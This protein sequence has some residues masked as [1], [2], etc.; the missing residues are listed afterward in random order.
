[1]YQWV[2]DQRKAELAVS[3]QDNVDNALSIDSTF[4]NGDVGKL[5]NWVYDFMMRRHLGVR[6]RTCK[7]QITESAMP[8]VKQDYCRNVMTSYHNL[9]GNPKYLLYMDETAVYLNCAS[10]RTVHPKGE[11][12]IF[13]MVGGSSSMRFTLAVTIAMDGSKLLLFVIFKGT[14]VGSIARSLP[15][16]LSDGV[17]GFVQAKAWMDNRTMNI[18]YNTVIKPYIA[19]YSGCSGLLLDDLKCHQEFQFIVGRRW[20]IELHDSS[21]LHCIVT[22]L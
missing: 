10:N 9:I 8:S 17:I 11:K 16:I 4:R 19:G 21:S 20:S 7:S 1:M 6:T 13:I 5:N 2:I 3:M 14:P 18:W 15:S 22:T 12:T